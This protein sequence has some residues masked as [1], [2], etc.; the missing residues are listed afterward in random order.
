[1]FQLTVSA[2]VTYVRK[3]IDELTSAEQIGLLMEPDAINL[4]RLVEGCIV[5]AA[6]KAYMSAPLLS[7]NGKKAT[8][9]SDFSTKPENGVVTIT[10][11]TPVAKILS[12]KCS[13]SSVVITNLIPEDSA[14]GRKQLDAYV[15]GTY[16]DP[17][18]VLLKRWDEDHMPIMRYYTVKSTTPSPVFD[19][20]YLPY[21]YL[22]EGVVE[23]A[24]RMEYVVLNLI[25]ASVLDSF[26]EFDAADRFRLKA[27]EYMEG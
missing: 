4:H 18:L 17:K 6:V 11:K 25:V 22:E 27:K 21:P 7:L 16:D 3:A 9:T 10:M 20:E 24:P 15:R 13:D 23:I 5:E 1:M 26:R 2:A 19:I 14:E 12:V 8:S